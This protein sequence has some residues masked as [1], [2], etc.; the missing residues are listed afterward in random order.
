MKDGFTDEPEKPEKG[1]TSPKRL[2]D[3]TG[4]AT[5]KVAG[6]RLLI[7]NCPIAE[8]HYQQPDA[9]GHQ[10]QESCSKTRFSALVSRNTRLLVKR[11]NIMPGAVLADFAP[12]GDAW[13]CFP[14]VL[15]PKGG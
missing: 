5:L 13:C 2:G 10:R 14:L 12:L 7:S 15:Q 8:A 9:Q 6:V 3:H 1:E 4:A 11:D